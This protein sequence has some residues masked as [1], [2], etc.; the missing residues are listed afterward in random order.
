M[1]PSRSGLKFNLTQ[2][3]QRYAES[4]FDFGDGPGGFAA[5]A[6]F[7]V[8]E[9]LLERW[10]RIGTRDLSECFGGATTNFNARVRQQHTAKRSHGVIVFHFTQRPHRE[11]ANAR[12]GR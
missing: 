7:R 9:S 1:P 8:V 6:W 2:R 3:T 11:F 5:D 10:K 12:C 4:A